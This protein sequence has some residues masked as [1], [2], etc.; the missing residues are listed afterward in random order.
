MRKRRGREAMVGLLEERKREG[1]TM[2][3][4]AERSGVPVQTLSYWAGK[5]RREGTG[6]GSLVPVELVE[7]AGDGRVAIE[8]GGNVR[9]RVERGFDAAHLLRV[10][11]V[12]GSRC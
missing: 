1:L 12:L 11:E 4:L 7:D 5:L 8:V 9:V 6:R 2:R 10:V 3:S